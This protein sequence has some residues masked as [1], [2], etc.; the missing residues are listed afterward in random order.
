MGLLGVLLLAMFGDNEWNRIPLV[1]F[2][3]LFFLGGPMSPILVNYFASPIRMAWHD[4]KRHALILKFRWVE[5]AQMTQQIQS[6]VQQ[7]KAGAPS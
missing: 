2:F 7:D 3:A 4:R 1:V 5:Y 6:Q